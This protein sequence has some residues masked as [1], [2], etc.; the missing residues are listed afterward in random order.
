[1][2]ELI[3]GVDGS[4]GARRAVA[5]AAGEAALRGDTL[6]LVTA[7]Q[8][9]W[10]TAGS[11]VDGPVRTRLEQAAAAR[12]ETLLDDLVGQLSPDLPAVR[13]E[14]LFG[15]PAAVLRD[16]AA[17][18]TA[19]VVGS[20]GC[21]GFTGLLLGSVSQQIA[22]HAMCPVVVVPDTATHEQ[23]D[24]S[25][26][27]VGVDGSEHSRRALARAGEE[28]SLR[29]ARLDVVIVSPLPLPMPIGEPVPVDL[30]GDEAWTTAP[31]L[32]GL[33]LSHELRRAHARAAAEWQAQAQRVA[34]EDLRRL[35]LKARAR[36]HVV[37]NLHPA[38]ALVEAADDT[39]LL[40]VGSRG[41]G[42]FA[43]MVLG[44]VSQHCV[45]HARVPVM[46]VPS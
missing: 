21:G 33:E 43:G 16:R 25:T 22:A 17:G 23:H 30:A 35:H 38:Q 4:D 10:P 18:L 34:Y 8:H 32:A 15:A 45:R 40:V 1:M 11:D 28:A 12:A 13:R 39:G 31:E 6:T 3:A 26:V 14:V 42:G 44:S 24:G 29:D 9:T 27:V 20:R 5:W 36:M 37:A 19:L 41:R 46:V 2:G 7:I